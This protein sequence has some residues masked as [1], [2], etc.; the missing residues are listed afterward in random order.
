MP[1]SIHY[2]ARW[3]LAHNICLVEY[4][5]IFGAEKEDCI[6]NI[7]CGRGTA[8]SKVW[9]LTRPPKDLFW[10]GEQ[11]SSAEDHPP[12]THNQTHFL[13]K[14]THTNRQTHFQ[15]N[16]A[17]DYYY[18][19]S[20]YICFRGQR[21]GLVSS[22]ETLLLWDREWVRL[23]INTASQCGCWFD[24]CQLTGWLICSEGFPFFALRFL[25][26]LYLNTQA[27]LQIQ[28]AARTSDL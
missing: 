3:L 10:G 27:W 21:G 25:T 20:S 11:F 19:L 16:R 6:F 5:R 24:C 8:V 2:D 15:T 14:D 23:H 9:P 13:G 4:V 26:S 28:P 22:A 12:L 7:L 17:A 18:N 1:T